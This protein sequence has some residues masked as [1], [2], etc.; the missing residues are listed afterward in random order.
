MPI[1]SSLGTVYGLLGIPTGMIERLEVVKGPASTLYGTEAVAGLINVITRVP[2]K[3]P[4]F[5]AET[6]VNSWGEAAFDVGFTKQNK[7]TSWLS[8]LSVFGFDRVIDKNNDGFTDL[9][10]Q[11]RLSWFNKVSFGKNKEGNLALRLLI[12]ERWGGQTNYNKIFR[13]T[14]LVY[15]ESIDTRRFEFLGKNKLGSNL[16]L[17][18]SFVSHYQDSYYGV[19]PFKA[20]QDIAF[21]QSLYRFSNNTGSY[22]IGLPLKFTFYD[23]NTV[24][25]ASNDINQPQR[26]FN[27]AL[28]SQYEKNLSNQLKILL[29]YRIDYF[30]NKKWVQSPRL[31]IKYQSVDK[32]SNLRLN[33]GNG[34][35]WVNVFS[36]DHAALTGARTVYIADDLRPERSQ[37]IS[38]NFERKI[39]LASSYI[40]LDV[41]AFYSYFSN[42]IIPDYDSHPEKIFYNN[43]SG[44]LDTKGLNLSLAYNHS[45]GFRANATL[46]LLDMRNHENKSWTRPVLTE[47]A[48]GTVLLSYKINQINTSLDYTLNWLSK[49][50]LPLQG[51]FDPRPEYSPFTSFHNIQLTKTLNKNFEFFAGVKNLFNFLPYRGLPFLIANAR[52]PFDKNVT[53]DSSGV[54][55]ISPQNPYGLT[56][57]PSYVY[58]PLQG[59]RVFGGFRV[60]F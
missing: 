23:D 33:Y 42:K 35:R 28:F 5:W 41:T 10:L 19:T 48:S 14:D 4:K 25:T 47:R 58:A 27:P 36:E 52:D 32:L 30:S 60:N 13:G 20:R 26:L 57:D 51:A 38:V 2:G 53:F 59:T 8:G 1:V 37:N 22:L 9:S 44:F 39:P 50:R 45:S 7:N 43:L 16:D 49:M 55:L 6:N 21:A 56:F 11:K 40:G 24:I 29:A 54:A 31:A 18:Y 17:N 46:S 12:E 3:G 15:G 34:F